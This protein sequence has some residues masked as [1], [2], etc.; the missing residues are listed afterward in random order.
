MKKINKGKEPP[1]LLRHRKKEQATYDNYREKDE[2]RDYL[3]TEQG[4]IC[5]YCMQRIT[6]NAETMKIEHYKPQK[7][8]PQ[9]QL[10]YQNLL[11]SCKG[12]DG[13]PKHLPRHCDTSKGEQEI[14]IN[15]ID[16]ISN[17]ERVIKYRKNGWIYSDDPIIN[18][19][20][21]NIL[22]LNTQIL[23][24]YRKAVIDQ[25]IKELTNIKGKKAAWSVS[26]IKNKIQ[27]YENTTAGKYKPYCQIIIYFLKKRIGEN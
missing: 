1:S 3:A 12:N 16:K 24:Y 21:N 13:G 18:Y 10:D 9:L 2:L 15:P 5:C 17:C 23:V 20:L 8:Y 27:V 22:N 6:S 14:T 11:A 4:Y 7:K 26:D 19:E 25:V